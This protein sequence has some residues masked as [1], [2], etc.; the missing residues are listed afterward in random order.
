[1]YLSSLRRKRGKSNF[2][3]FLFLTLII[4]T[5]QA[6]K[7]TNFVRPVSY[8]VNHEAELIKIPASLYSFQK[9]SLVGVSGIGK[10]QL[11]R[12][13]VDL[14]F[15]KYK[16]IWFFDANINLN[17]QFTQ[18]AKAINEQSNQTMV[19]EGINEAQDSVL[20][21]LAPQNNFLIVV[22]N[23]KVNKNENANL[24]INWKNNGHIIFCSQD[25]VTLPNIIKI[26]YLDFSASK[27]LISNIMPNFSAIS[28]DKLAKELGGYPITIAKS[29]IFLN[30]NSYIT[31]E[32]YTKYL[33]RN[34]D[35]ME[36]YVNILN[37]QLNPSTI[38]LLNQLVFFNNQNLSKSLIKK[39][40]NSESFIDD[41]VDLNRYQ[42][43]SLKS[44]N[45]EQPVFE[46]HDKLKEAVLAGM[47][48]GVLE[49]TLSNSV[50]K[51]NKFIPKGKNTKQELVL[52]DD[53]LID[54]LEELLNNCEKYKID[55]L[56]ILELKKNLM[57]F[58]LGMGIT[59]CTDFKEWFFNKKIEF[60]KKE[61]PQ[62]IKAVSAEF[63]ILIGIYDYFIN[64]D[65]S[66]AMEM[67]HEA[68]T[69]IENLQGH[70]DLRYMVYS[71]LAQAYVYNAEMDDALTYIKKAKEINTKFLGIELDATLLLYIESKYYLSAG[72]YEKSL[73]SIN[74]FIDII[75]DHPID[76]Y[77]APIYVMKA[78]ILNSIGDYNSA[79]DIIK[80]IYDK[81]I[82]EI[83]K[84]NAGGIRLRVIIGLSRSEFGKGEFPKANKYA[85]QAVNIYQ[86]DESRKNLDLRVSVDTDLADAYI[87]YADGLSVLKKEKEAL[88]YY[89]TAE[90]IYYNKYNTK[91][92]H[93]DE[94]SILYFK[95]LKTASSI[96]DQYSFNKFKKRHVDKFGINHFRSQEI[97]KI[98]S[99]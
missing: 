12:Q 66:S 8:Y 44:G 77:F 10:T 96:R 7:V 32:E 15:K 75:K 31:L 40:S 42:I 60:T 9:T 57:S 81:E 89:A 74:Q 55:E 16:L 53:T 13:Y 98:P 33:T 52:K 51:V 3:V 90:A 46:M 34:T 48:G 91:I 28:T 97:L 18:L 47:K 94:V 69:I 38:R 59:R 80:N 58:Y 36:T 95:A 50:E 11:A 68:E 20:N 22:D 79:Y 4:H 78:T 67:L 83:T 88:H 17:Q 30:S 29:T 25:T 6:T 23:L 54:N 26:P 64:A 49:K 82:N 76:Y 70:D 65:A 71:Q 21:Y 99:L 2:L 92:K 45:K 73:W 5:T 27:K 93:L 56:Q 87:A 62:Y 1:M 19:A 84:G 61:V 41:L 43:I 24:F 86:Q 37:H 63:L 72:D 39:L 14:N 35:D 85:N